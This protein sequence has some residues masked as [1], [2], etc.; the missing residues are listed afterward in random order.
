MYARA[1]NL[2]TCTHLLQCTLRTLCTHTLLLRSHKLSH[3]YFAHQCTHVLLR[4]LFVSMHRALPRAGCCTVLSYAAPT[5]FVVQR[6][7]SAPPPDR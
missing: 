3:A 4:A 1:R 6:E 7:G 5:T 2:H